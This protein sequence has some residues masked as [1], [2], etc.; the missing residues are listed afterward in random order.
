MYNGLSNGFESVGSHALSAH[1]VNSIAAHSQ[2][3]SA[4]QQGRQIPHSRDLQSEDGRGSSIASK[5]IS[6]RQ[7]IALLQRRGIVPR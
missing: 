6:C 3:P 4:S 1:N 5:P 2:G 7:F